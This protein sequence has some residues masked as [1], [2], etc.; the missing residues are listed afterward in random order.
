[1]LAVRHRDGTSF[2]IRIPASRQVAF[3]F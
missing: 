1:M 2:K 3:S